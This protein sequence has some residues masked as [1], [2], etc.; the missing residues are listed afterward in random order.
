MGGSAAENSGGLRGL[1]YGVTKDYVM[2]MEVVLANGDKVRF[3]PEPY[4]FHYV[5]AVDPDRTYIVARVGAVA[6]CARV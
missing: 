1:K 5:R 2:G 4:P 3:G 6:R